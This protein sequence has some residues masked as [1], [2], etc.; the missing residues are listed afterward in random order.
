MNEEKLAWDDVVTEYNNAI[1]MKVTHAQMSNTLQNIK[2]HAKT[3]TDRKTTG[4]KKIKLK[5]WEKQLLLCLGPAD[6]PIF[7]KV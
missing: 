4:N 2:N 5:E 6:N 1:G 7:T 3:K